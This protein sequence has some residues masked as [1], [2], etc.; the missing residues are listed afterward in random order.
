MRVARA[1]RQVVPSVRAATL[2]ASR[3]G[4]ARAHHE[5]AAMIATFATVAGIGL[6]AFAARSLVA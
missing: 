5:G 3:Y 6:L 4:F 1:H 2:S